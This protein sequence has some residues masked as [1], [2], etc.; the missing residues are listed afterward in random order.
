MSQMSWEPHDPQAPDEPVAPPRRR[1]RTVLTAILM[2][3]LVAGA[4]AGA[5]VGWQQRTVA[6]GWQE[7]ADVLERQRDDA[8]GRAEALGEQLAELSILVETIGED[9]SILADRLAEL[10][11]EKAQAE[12]RASFTRTDLEQLAA[13]V[14]RAVS[15]LNACVEDALVLQ[16]D[17]VAAFNEFAAGRAVDI[18]TLNDRLSATRERCNTARLSGAEAVGLA[19]SLR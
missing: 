3:M 15:Q 2:L 19:R 9:R 7:R 13:T 11:G 17:T 12:D 4:G 8:V 5:G 1:R 18:A 6:A 14:D 16:S 10:A